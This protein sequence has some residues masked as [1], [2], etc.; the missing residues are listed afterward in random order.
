MNLTKIFTVSGKPGLFRL[1]SQNS[2]GIVAESLLTGKTSTIFSK[3]P[4]SI[5]DDICIYTVD[6]EIKLKE[7]LRT[8]FIQNEAKPIHLDQ[9]SG[10]DF[11]KFMLSIIP[12]YDQDKVYNSDIQKLI[13]W[14]NLLLEKNLVD[15]EPDPVEEKTT[16]EK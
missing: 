7:A 2:Y 11:R 1:I 12:N 6:G 4:V 8:I 15:A 9:P 16:E 5:L 14:Y 10:S 13:K 3:E